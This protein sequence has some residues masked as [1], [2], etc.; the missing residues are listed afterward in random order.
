MTFEEFLKNYPDRWNAAMERVQAKAMAKFM[1]DWKLPELG[2]Y[3]WNE[4]ETEK[5]AVE[6]ENATIPTI[7]WPPAKGITTVQQKK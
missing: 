6:V 5:H 3:V 7:P 4:I 2:V 1:D